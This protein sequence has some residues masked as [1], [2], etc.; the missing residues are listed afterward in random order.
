MTLSRRAKKSRK[1]A[2]VAEL[3]GIQE[4]L[5]RW[6]PIGVIPEAIADG[7]EPDEYDSYAGWIYRMLASGC[8]VDE[9]AKH[10]DYCRSQAMGLGH[11]SADDLQ[12]AKELMDWWAKGRRS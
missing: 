11:N 3:G 9:L 1:E 4:I 7:R 10:L 12:F 5:R 2:G 8:S 6:D